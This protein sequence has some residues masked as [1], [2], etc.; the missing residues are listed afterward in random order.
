[1]QKIRLLIILAYP[2]LTFGQERKLYEL[3][4]KDKSYY[5][6]RNRFLKDSV[7]Y[8][9]QTVAYDDPNSIDEESWVR[10]VIKI[11]DTVAFLNNKKIDLDKDS[12]LFSYYFNAWNAWVPRQDSTS[13]SG[14]INLI[15]ATIQEITLKLDLI[16]INLKTKNQYIYRGIRTFTGVNT[17]S[18]FYS[19]H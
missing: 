14:Q 18:E 15:S 10:L 17:I 1:M 13:I 11:K 12:L 8:F 3:E 9:S 2:L 5:T 19:S 4:Y 7:W 6:E 16:I